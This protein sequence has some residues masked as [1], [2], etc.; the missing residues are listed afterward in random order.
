MKWFTSSYSG[1]GGGNC[2]EVAPGWRKS[3]YSG[4][5]G[6]DCLEV[7]TAPD[8]VHV[9][10]SKDRQGPALAFSPEAWTAFAAFAADQSV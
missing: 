9:R 1:T 4:G 2:I 3:S 10:D 5:D 6:G 8:A 7:A